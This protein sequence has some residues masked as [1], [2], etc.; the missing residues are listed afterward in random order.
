MNRSITQKI[1]L[2]IVLVT[3]MGAGAMSSAGNATKDEAQT[4]T[5]TN[6]AFIMGSAGNGTGLKQSNPHT[7]CPEERRA[8]V[9][10]R[11]NT[12]MKNMHED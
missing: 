10:S 12:S 9:V 8:A 7:A 3:L 2:V 6:T 11:A 1:L 5:W 4:Q